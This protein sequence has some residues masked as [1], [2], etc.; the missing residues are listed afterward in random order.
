MTTHEVDPNPAE[1]VDD[2]LSEVT[3]ALVLS[4][5]I[6]QIRS[7]PAQLRSTVYELA[8]VRL[9]QEAA[10]ENPALS[11]E[12]KQRIL[13]S[14]EVA[15]EGVEDFSR[16]TGN[17]YLPG[18]GTSGAGEP[19]RLH[20]SDGRWLAK[21]DFQL[22]PAERVI[23][24]ES[25][26]SAGGQDRKVRRRVLVRRVVVP[27]IASVAVVAIG[28]G[29]LAGSGRLERLWSKAKSSNAAA[30]TAPVVPAAPQLSAGN[31]MPPLAS[32]FAAVQGAGRNPQL[33]G[34]PIPATYGVY[35][36]NEQQLNELKVLPARVPDPRVRISTPILTPSRTVLP[37]GKV[38]FLVFRRDFFS[39]A[40]ERV[41][42]RVV[43][44]VR[45]LQFKTTETAASGAELS[46]VWAIRSNAYEY[47]VAPVRDN[48]EMFL[49]RPEKTNFALPAGRYVLVLKG[50]GYDFSVAGPVSDP[51][52]CLERINASN[53]TFYSECRAP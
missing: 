15:I 45:T 12:E 53:G 13:A 20:G 38:A 4:R 47:R 18:F 16:R 8:R 21:P 17:S 31:A 51:A 24:I 46:D 28:L 34:V 32:H 50:R 19:D 35:A 40:P 41:S 48:P 52:H 43:A 9:E 5:A 25:S 37:N 42:I 22:G 29:L 3:F 1:A 26:A 11:S 30:T 10:K 39:S 27:L 6:D 44:K 2:R 49:L 36:V 23:L 7:D 14:L 33:A